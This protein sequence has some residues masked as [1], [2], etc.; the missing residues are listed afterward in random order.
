MLARMV[1]GLN[2]LTSWSARLGLPKCWDYRCEPPRPAS[3][4]FLTRWSISKVNACIHSLFI[5]YVLTLRRFRIHHPKAC[6]LAYW[7]LWPKKIWEPAN[8]GKL[9]L[10]HNCLK[11]S[12]SFC[13]EKFSSLKE[14]S[15][16][17]GICIRKKAAWRQLLSPESLTKQPLFIIHFVPLPFHNLSP[18]RPQKAHT[19][20]PWPFFQSPTLVPLHCM[21]M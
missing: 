8:T 12:R 9:H 2:L 1:D 7:L 13:K 10:S 3:N 20:I 19:P 18:P 16:S 6:H 5:K 17:K 14:I 11:D 21:G 4:I 15:M